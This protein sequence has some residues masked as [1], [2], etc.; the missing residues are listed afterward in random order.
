MFSHAMKTAQNRILQLVKIFWNDSYTRPPSEL[1][2]NVTTSISAS[3]KSILNIGMRMYTVYTRMP[4]QIRLVDKWNSKNKNGGNLF[5]FLNDLHWTLL[6]Y[7]FNE[8][9]RECRLVQMLAGVQNFWATS[10]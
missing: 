9:W 7:F 10:K 3:I 2:R 5:D 8:I 1:L 4:W 6:K